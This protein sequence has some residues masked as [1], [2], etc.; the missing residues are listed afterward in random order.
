MLENLH[1]TDSV[2]ASTLNDGGRAVAVPPLPVPLVVDPRV[3][4]LA[5][6]ALALLEDRV[7]R[8]LRTDYKHS[9]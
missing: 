9:A 5:A 1:A 7:A 6:L 3:A 2:G 8:R 4:L